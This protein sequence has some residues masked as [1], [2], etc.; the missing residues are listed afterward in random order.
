MKQWEGRNALIHDLEKK[1]S[2]EMGITE[3][4]STGSQKY[5]VNLVDRVTQRKAG[6][7]IYLLRKRKRKT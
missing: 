4:S 6:N 1:K 7:Y 2:E 5:T 3:L